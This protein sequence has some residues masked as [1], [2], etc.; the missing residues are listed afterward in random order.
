MSLSEELKLDVYETNFDTLYNFNKIKSL[1]NFNS[2]KTIIP[3]C[4]LIILDDVEYI[5]Y[6][7][8]LYIVPKYNNGNYSFSEWKKYLFP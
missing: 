2:D 3:S 7:G 6:Q 1:L 8:L 5:T 4:H